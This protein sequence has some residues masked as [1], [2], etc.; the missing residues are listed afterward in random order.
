MFSLT[1]YQVSRFTTYV[2]LCLATNTPMLSKCK[3]SRPFSVEGTFDFHYVLLSL[4]CLVSA[5]TYDYGSAAYA[6]VLKVHLVCQCLAVAIA[7]TL[8]LGC[9]LSVAPQ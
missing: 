1:L 7:W 3:K 6:Y 2:P 4:S 5:Q 9:S 8:P